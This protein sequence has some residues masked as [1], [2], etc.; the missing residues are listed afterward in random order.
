MGFQNFVVSNKIHHLK[1]KVPDLVRNNNNI[2]VSR[3]HQGR[4]NVHSNV[5]LPANAG[6]I[7]Y[8]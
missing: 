6:Y 1:K 7:R 3:F 4:Q 8:H 5:G 2:F